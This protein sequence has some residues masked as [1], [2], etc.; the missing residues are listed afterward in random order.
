MF[1]LEPVDMVILLQALVL[2][3]NKYKNVLNTRRRTLNVWYYE[4]EVEHCVT[5]LPKCI[6]EMS[7]LGNEVMT[8]LSFS[9]PVIVFYNY[10]SNAN[11]IC[12]IKKALWSNLAA[13][14]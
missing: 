9:V 14:L 11:C 8:P 3:S 2:C 4:H 6:W 1:G 7:C 10:E 5:A 12:R 13:C